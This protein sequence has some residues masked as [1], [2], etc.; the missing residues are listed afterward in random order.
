MASGST[1]AQIARD[2]GVSRMTVYRAL[3]TLPSTRDKSAKNVTT[4]VSG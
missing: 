2:L 4:L 1:K 3:Q